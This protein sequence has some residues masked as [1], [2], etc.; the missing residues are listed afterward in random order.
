MK[1]CNAIW[2]Y[3]DEI[4]QDIDTLQLQLNNGHKHFEEEGKGYN[5]IRINLDVMKEE[6]D[7]LQL[8]LSSTQTWYEEE[9]NNPNEIQIDLKTECNEVKGER[10]SPLETYKYTDK[11]QLSA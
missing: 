5:K 8:Q 6:R 7:T 9:A 4:R 10:C 11:M 1:E 3:C 2:V